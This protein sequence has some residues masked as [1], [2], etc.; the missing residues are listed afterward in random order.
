MLSRVALCHWMCAIIVGIVVDIRREIYVIHD[1]GTR[2]DVT[3]GRGRQAVCSERDLVSCNPAS[4][5]FVWYRVI[6]AS[7]VRWKEPSKAF[8]SVGQSIR[9]VVSC[10]PKSRL[11]LAMRPKHF[12]FLVFF[13][14]YI[15]HTPLPSGYRYSFRFSIEWW[16]RWVD[17]SIFWSLLQSIASFFPDVRPCLGNRNS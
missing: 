5:L 13:F 10:C 15:L 6:S 7:V 8:C 2:I 4:G 11:F 14:Y 12:V 1:F 16:I 3:F 17:V 9:L